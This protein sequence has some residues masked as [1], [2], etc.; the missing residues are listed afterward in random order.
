ML[1]VGQCNDAY[2]ALQI[3]I[4]LAGALDCKVTDLPLSFAVSWFEQKVSFCA[5]A[6]YSHGLV[7]YYL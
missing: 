4:A 1:D 7:E 2:G 3:A 6:L 5:C